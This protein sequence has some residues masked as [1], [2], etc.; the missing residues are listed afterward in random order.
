M[1]FAQAQTNPVLAAAQRFL[2][3][4]DWKQ[5]SVLTLDFTCRGRREY[6]ILGATKGAVVQIEGRAIASRTPEAVVAAFSSGLSAQPQLFQN[7]AANAEL[8]RL[9]IEDNDFTKKEFEASIGEVPEGL[10]SSK[11]CKGLNLSDGER[12][13]VHLYWNRKRGR[14]GAW[15]L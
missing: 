15:S 8:A 13:S 5:Q 2:P 6:A 7:S 11:T 14:I 3:E 4:V 1:T 9:T 10:Q 12:D